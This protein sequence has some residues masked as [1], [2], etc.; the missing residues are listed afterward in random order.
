MKKTALHFKIVSWSVKHPGLSYIAI[1]CAM[2]LT[3]LVCVGLTLFAMKKAPVPPM[4]GPSASAVE[5]P[6][7][8]QKTG[9]TI[10]GQQMIGSKQCIFYKKVSNGTRL[11]SCYV[12]DGEKWIF[13]Q[14]F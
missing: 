3:I 1:G 13:E 6:A 10:A 2:A 12:K 14:S 8:F 5:T 4:A 11:T 7:T 9:W